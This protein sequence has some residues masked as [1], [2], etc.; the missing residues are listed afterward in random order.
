[1]DVFGDDWGGGGHMGGMAGKVSA[2]RLRGHFFHL[3]FHESIRHA[4]AHQDD[5]AWLASLGPRLLMQVAW[6]TIGRFQ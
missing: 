3:A 1:M 2:H 5:S 6:R 4:L